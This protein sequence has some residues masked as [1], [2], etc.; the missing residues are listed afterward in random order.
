MDGWMDGQ[1]DGDGKQT[2]ID[3]RYRYMMIETDDR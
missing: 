1:M 3:N 2:Q